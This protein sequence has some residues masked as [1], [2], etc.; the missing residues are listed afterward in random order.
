MPQPSSSSFRLLHLTWAG[1]AS[2]L[3]A[4]LAFPSFLPCLGVPL[5]R[6]SVAPCLPRMQCF[7][8]GQSS[9]MD[10][11]SLATK[12]TELSRAMPG[13]GG[14][15]SSFERMDARML[16]IQVR[17]PSRKASSTAGVSVKRLKEEFLEELGA[18]RRRRNNSEC[19]IDVITVLKDTFWNT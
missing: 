8:L 14:T 16:R 10:W 17:Q 3:A 4:P 5:A 6:L 15:E 12:S 1:L 11:H 9:L 19:E 18:A 7:R 2:S 13:S